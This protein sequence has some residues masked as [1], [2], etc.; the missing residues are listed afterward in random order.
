M[1]DNYDMRGGVDAW[2]WA[3][4]PRLTD[5]D[6]TEMVWEYHWTDAWE[7]FMIFQKGF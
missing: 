1:S 2:M 3:E 5:D 7:R 4:R 6:V